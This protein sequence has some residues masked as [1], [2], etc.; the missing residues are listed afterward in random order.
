MQYRQLDSNGDYILRNNQAFTSG[1]NAVAQAIKTKLALL[2]GEWWEDINDGF[3]LFQSV[4]NVSPNDK[5]I[6]AIDLLVRNRILETTDVTSIQSYT[7]NFDI[8]SRTYSFSSAVNTVYGT[9]NI[10]GVI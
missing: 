1:T 5:S 10:Q 3:P 8:K 9:T 4:L 6:Q 7:S 2:K